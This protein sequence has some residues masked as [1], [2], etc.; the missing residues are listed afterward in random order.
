MNYDGIIKRLQALAP[1][2]IYNV[3]EDGKIAPGNFITGPVIINDLVLNDRDIL[4]QV[5]VISGKIAYWGRLCAQCKR[6]WEITERNY[7]IWRDSLYLQYRQGEVKKYTE[8]EIDALI[9]TTPE[10]NI[11]YNEQER[12]EEA[13]NAACAITEAWKAKKEMLKLAVYRRNTEL[14][15]NLAI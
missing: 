8:K 14:G 10:Y 4:E 1:F 12:A 2:N 9:R 15:G 13:Y 3:Q 6:V 11:Y 7:R 5:Q